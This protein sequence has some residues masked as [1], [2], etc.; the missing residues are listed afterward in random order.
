MPAG[1]AP[2]GGPADGAKDPLAGKKQSGSGAK[3]GTKGAAGGK[4]DSRQ[5][6]L[7]DCLAAYDPATNMTRREWAATCRRTLREYPEVR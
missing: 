5:K 4:N 7:E 6:N 2:A 1:K 3:A